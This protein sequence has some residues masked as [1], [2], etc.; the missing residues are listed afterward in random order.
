MASAATYLDVLKWNNTTRFFVCGELEIIKTI[1]IQYEP[2]PLP[3][4]VSPPLL[5]QP[6]LLVRVEESVHQVI[7][8]IFRNL[9]RFC[10][11][12]LNERGITI[13]FK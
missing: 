9:E 3:A 7:S 11:D 13:E 6:P 10:F 12:A 8:V 5:P 1:I 2:S 4:L